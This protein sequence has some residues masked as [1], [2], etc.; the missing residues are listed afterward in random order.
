MENV[1]VIGILV[2]LIGSAVAYIV[3]AKKNGAKCIGCP[4]SGSCSSCGDKKQ[5]SCDCGCQSDTK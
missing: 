4:A 3:K 2:I 1:I 5:A